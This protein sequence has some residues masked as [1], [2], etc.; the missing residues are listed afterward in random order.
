MTSVQALRP[1]LCARLPSGAR[2]PTPCSS[3]ARACCAPLRRAARRRA[4][5]AAR[6]AP[7]PTHPPTPPQPRE[8]RVHAPTSCR[9]AVARAP[10]RAPT[11]Y[12]WDR[13]GTGLS[14]SQ[15]LARVRERLPASAQRS[16]RANTGLSAGSPSNA[17][18]ARRRRRQK[19]ANGPLANVEYVVEYS[20][21]A[22]CERCAHS[23]APPLCMRPSF[24]VSAQP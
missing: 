16:V 23:C 2:S 24:R 13:L 1:E 11:Y 22:C 17:P 5:R 18:D 8:A 15:P 20:A 4:R 3:P 7:R 6:R 14:K 9:R 19:S 12:T 21:R 10:R